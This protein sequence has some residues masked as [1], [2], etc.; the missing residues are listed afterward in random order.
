VAAQAATGRHHEARSPRGDAHRIERSKRAEN[1]REKLSGRG[2][3]RRSNDKQASRTYRRR[4]APA[5]CP[6]SGKRTPG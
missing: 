1:S 4:S 5:S 2:L 3:S 6:T